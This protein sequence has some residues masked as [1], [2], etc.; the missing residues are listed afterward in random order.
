MKE[1]EM[2]TK[3]SVMSQSMMFLLLMLF[4]SGCGLLRY[5]VK[6]K[7]VDAETGKPI[8][9]AAVGVHWYDYS[10]Q[11]CLLPYASGYHQIET[12]S[13]LTDVNGVFEIP[14]R[15]FKEYHLGFYK[16][17]YVC[18]S[19]GDIFHPEFYDRWQASQG[20]V[21]GEKIREPRRGFWLAPGM[22]IRLE[23]WKEG[24]SVFG[25][26]EFVGSINRDV[27][28]ARHFSDATREERSIWEQ[29][30][31]ELG[32]KE[33]RQIEEMRRQDKLKKERESQQ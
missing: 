27:D 26:A 33:N 22:V 1:C 10:I 3:L 11:G 19:E 25:H 13:A 30:Q 9:G 16:K 20:K 6:G 14:K 23:P 21:G 28:G 15:T 8:E 12:A 5:P 24:Y 31:H 32:E 29:F 4:T 18:W 7:V 17:G 2:K